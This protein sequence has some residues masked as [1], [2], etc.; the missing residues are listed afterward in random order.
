MNS[1]LL[2]I[3]TFS[4]WQEGQKKVI[5]FD[6]EEAKNNV[7]PLFWENSFIELISI[8]KKPTK[9]DII[10]DTVKYYSEDTSRRGLDSQGLCTYCSTDN[11]K[12]AVGRWMLNPELYQGSFVNLHFISSTIDVENADATLLLE[13]QGHPKMFW[14]ELQT[15]HD[16]SRYW[17]LAGLTEQGLDYVNSIKKEYGYI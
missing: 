12:C 5:A 2:K 8:G 9:L 1:D 3:Y 7:K 6:L 16:S 4:T 14:T 17:N 11:K 13:Y 10:E 15:L